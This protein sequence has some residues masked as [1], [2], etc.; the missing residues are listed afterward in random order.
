MEFFSFQLCAVS[1]PITSYQYQLSE[2]FVLIQYF[3]TH[4][5][6]LYLSVFLVMCFTVKIKLACFCDSRVIE[7][8]FF[9]K[10]NS[11]DSDSDND[12]KFSSSNNINCT[13]AHNNCNNC[14][15]ANNNSNIYSCFCNCCYTLSSFQIGLCTICLSKVLITRAKIKSVLLAMKNNERNDLFYYCSASTYIQREIKFSSYLLFFKGELRSLNLTPS[16]T[17]WFLQRKGLVTNKLS[18]D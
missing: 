7:E 18:D 6:L 2:T 16:S 14:N 1:S 13:N 15:N 12:S 8:L 11:S 3:S 4:F 10:R 9:M 17:C 5:G